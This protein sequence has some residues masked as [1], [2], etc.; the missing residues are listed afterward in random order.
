MSHDSPTIRRHFDV[1]AEVTL[2]LDA[3]RQPEGEYGGDHVFY[4]ETVNIPLPS[5]GGLK[6]HITVDPAQAQELAGVVL[7]TLRLIRVRHKV[8]R[9]SKIYRTLNAG[10]YGPDMPGKFIAAY[11]GDRARF[12]RM[13]AVLD[14]VLMRLRVRGVK[15]GPW[16]LNRHVTPM[17]TEAQAGTSDLAS[18]C[19]VRS[20]R[21]S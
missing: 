1:H 19:E 12:E 9:S 7:P 4:A 18:Y 10:E 5:T 8:V 14:P 15:P 2:R 6:V 16:P 3:W 13:L 17:A 11:P 21:F 20:Y